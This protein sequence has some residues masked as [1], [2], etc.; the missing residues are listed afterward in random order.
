MNPSLKITLWQNSEQAEASRVIEQ[1]IIKRNLLILCCRR[2]CVNI[3]WNTGEDINLKIFHFY[4]SPKEFISKFTAVMSGLEA[5]VAYTNVLHPME[6]WS[7]VA[8]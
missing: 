3:L 4:V 1:D 7:C 5:V 6:N 8:F 2:G